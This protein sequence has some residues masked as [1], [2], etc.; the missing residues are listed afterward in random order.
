M[1][2]QRASEKGCKKENIES[3]RVTSFRER[4]ATRVALMSTWPAS[5]TTRSRRS[6]VRAQYERTRS[7][8]GAER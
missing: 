8:S 6:V 2:A 7:H 3:A 1:H 5:M 4:R